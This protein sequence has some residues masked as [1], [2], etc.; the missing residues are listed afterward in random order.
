MDHGRVFQGNIIEIGKADVSQNPVVIPIHEK[1]AV[2]G[3][4]IGS[5]KLNNLGHIHTLDL[6]QCHFPSPLDYPS[7]DK[8]TDDVRKPG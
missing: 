2:K 5:V 1:S 4:G 3:P 8:I 7:N 6:I